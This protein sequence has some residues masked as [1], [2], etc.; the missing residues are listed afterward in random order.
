[1]LRNGVAVGGKVRGLAFLAVYGKLALVT[2]TE[3]I[4]RLQSH[5]YSEVVDIAAKSGIPEPTVRKIFYA[6]TKNPRMDT[7]DA[8]RDYFQKQGKRAGAQ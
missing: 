4:R 2:N 5:P 1:L 7:I 3:V 6:Q 8:L